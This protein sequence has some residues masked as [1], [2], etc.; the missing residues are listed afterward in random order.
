LSFSF[1]SCLFSVGQPYVV[2]L[3]IKF[4][5]SFFFLLILYYQHRLFPLLCSLVK[6]QYASTIFF[7]YNASRIKYSKG[8]AAIQMQFQKV[9]Q[10][11]ERYN[12]Q[13]FQTINTTKTNAS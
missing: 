3:K 10:K 12:L 5:F 2:K 9:P 8:M 11:D 7:I 1:F 13:T 6:H 4:S